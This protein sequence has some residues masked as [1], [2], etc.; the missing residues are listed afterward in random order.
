MDDMKQLATKSLLTG[1]VNGITSFILFGNQ[2]VSVMGM[3]M[4]SY[5][6]SG[7]GGVGS[8]VAADLAHNYIMPHIP[9]NQKY[10]A[11]ESAALGIGISGGVNYLLM[12]PLG[13]S[14]ADSFL[15]GAGTYVAADYVWLQY[16][17]VEMS[18]LLFW[19]T[20]QDCPNFTEYEWWDVRVGWLSW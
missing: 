2:D 15:L 18:G 9:V 6:V 20:G 4:P 19:K 14:M 11:I 16:V 10:D 7:L 1:A 5:I 17:N 12:A 13:S 8:S 3:N